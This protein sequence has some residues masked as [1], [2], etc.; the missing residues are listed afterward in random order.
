MVHN[1]ASIAAQRKHRVQ[2]PKEGIFFIRTDEVEV[3]A[4][5]GEG[6]AM[7]TSSDRQKLHVARVGT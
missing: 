1:W 2:V 4:I 3:V 6:Q 7:E 5:R